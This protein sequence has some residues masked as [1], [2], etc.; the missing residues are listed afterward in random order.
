MPTLAED[1]GRAMAAKD[2]DRIRA[3]LHPQIDFQAMTPRRVWD[4]RSPE[5]IIDVVSTWFSDSDQVEDLEWLEA[6]D[7]AD[8]QRVGY[9]L[10]VRN[11]DGEFQVEQQAY[12]SERDGQ[13][14]WLRIMCSGY[15]EVARS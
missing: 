1:F 9:R 13:I 4:A 7:F 5:D 8:R 6:T 11:D 14:G 12:L 10:R 15:R 2:R 3:L